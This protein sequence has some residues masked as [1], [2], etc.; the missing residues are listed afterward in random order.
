MYEIHNAESPL[1]HIRQSNIM[2]NLKAL[3]NMCISPTAPISQ[4]M[5]IHFDSLRI[6]FRTNEATT[7]NSLEMFTSP[8]ISRSSCL[9]FHPS[10]FKSQYSCTI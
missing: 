10:F 9:Q 8:S 4:D 7:H 6:K 1:P 2:L 3:L 5:W